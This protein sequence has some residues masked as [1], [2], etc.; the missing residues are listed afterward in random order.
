MLGA[1]LGVVL[2]V[3]ICCN[4]IN[5]CPV[6]RSS[7]C[8]AILISRY[9]CDDF[10]ELDFQEMATYYIMMLHDGSMEVVL[11]QCILQS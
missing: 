9:R 3:A 6:S 2:G 7:L 10:G 11:L 1:V 8:A 5:C 4:S